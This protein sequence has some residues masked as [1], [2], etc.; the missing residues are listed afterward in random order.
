LLNYRLV[1][2]K[3][4]KQE[5]SKEAVHRCKFNATVLRQLY[6]ALHFNV[7]KLDPRLIVMEAPPREE[8]FFSS[9]DT[10]ERA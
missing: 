8:D 3:P 6:L 4:F 5:Q 1:S 2:Y 9:F 7:E 10:I